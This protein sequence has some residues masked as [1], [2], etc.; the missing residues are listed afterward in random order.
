MM[1]EG[2][3]TC[4]KLW[5]TQLSCG[6]SATARTR[7]E[8]NLGWYCCYW[9]KKAQSQ[10]EERRHLKHSLSLSLSMKGHHQPHLH[11][12]LDILSFAP[13]YCACWHIHTQCTDPVAYFLSC[14]SYKS[15]WDR[16]KQ[17]SSQW[18]RASLD[19][20]ETI[21]TRFEVWVE[22]GFIWA[23]VRTRAFVTGNNL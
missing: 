7:E 3:L 2:N 1:M 6:K 11:L 20:M 13:R 18:C 9:S 17:A 19:T 14:G 8:W 21:L 5:W 16:I 22:W 23:C 10:S 15:A 4:Q 12:P